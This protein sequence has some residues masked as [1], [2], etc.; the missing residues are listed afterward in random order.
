MKKFILLLFAVFYCNLAYSKTNVVYLDVQF[1]I[2]NSNLGQFYK[3]EIK[4][5][6]DLNKQNI[7]SKEKIIKNKEIEFNNQKNIISQDEI[8][9]KLNE[10]SVLV[11]EYQSYRADLNDQ[12]ILEKKKYSKKILTILNPLITKYVEK[13]NI[14]LVIEKKTIL[15]G[16]KSLDITKEILNI[17]NEETKD[18]ETQ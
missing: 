5:I 1:I 7:N 13:N 14:D 4:K 3:K 12:I 10:I 6:D 11:K 15:V 18:I 8:K 2:D 16:V 17:L 9:K